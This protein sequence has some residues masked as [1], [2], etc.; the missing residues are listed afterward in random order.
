[1]ANVMNN[2]N[3]LATIHYHLDL[4]RLTAAYADIRTNLLIIG[5]T[6]AWLVNAATSH[7]DHFV[8]TKRN[9][10]LK[11]SLRDRNKWQRLLELV[12]RYANPGASIYVFLLNDADT[13]KWPLFVLTKREETTFQLPECTLPATN[14]IMLWHNVRIPVPK[15]MITV[16][17]FVGWNEMRE[18]L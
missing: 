11:P 6:K 13:P 18:V 2:A 8:G 7:S 12:Y 17:A 15:E 1:M 3:V 9:I 16:N 4:Y 14:G 5:R 10:Q